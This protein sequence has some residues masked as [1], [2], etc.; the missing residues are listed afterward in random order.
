MNVILEFGPDSVN[1][2]IIDNGI[3]FETGIK[4]GG[5]GLLSMRQRAHAFGGKLKV[6]ST[7][8]EGTTLE[9]WFPG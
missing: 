4:T 6:Q 7:I 9:C 3:G 5:F 1:L 8:G 2:K